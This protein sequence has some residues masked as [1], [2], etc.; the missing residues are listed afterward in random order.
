MRL[1]TAPLGHRIPFQVAAEPL[2]LDFCDQLR[3]N[4][5]PNVLNRMGPFTPLIL[6]SGSA[7]NTNK[8]CSRIIN[9]F[10]TP[11]HIAQLYCIGCAIAKALSV[12]CRRLSSVCLS[13][14]LCIPAKRC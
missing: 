1:F 2:R 12:V 14:T 11:M 6:Q 13:V 4:V 9:V 3:A 8:C 10:S 7:K 5:K